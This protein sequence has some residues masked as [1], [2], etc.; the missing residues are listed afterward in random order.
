ML[1]WQFGFVI[2]FAGAEDAAHR[3]DVGQT[4]RGDK[5][6]SRSLP[7]IIFGHVCT[8]RVH[9]AA[10]RKASVTIVPKLPSCSLQQQQ[11]QRQ[12]SALFFRPSLLFLLVSL[13][14]SFL[15]LFSTSRHCAVP[16]HPARRSA[17]LLYYGCVFHGCHFSFSRSWTAAAACTATIR[18]LFPRRVIYKSSSFQRLLLHTWFNITHKAPF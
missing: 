2:H 7:V 14:F 4:L 6:P 13:F 16:F 12:I 9:Y 10:D 1:G 18:L 3:A 8:G 11:Q 17:T 5:G 15:F